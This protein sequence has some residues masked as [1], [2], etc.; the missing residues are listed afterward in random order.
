[1][2][3]A[4]VSGCLGLLNTDNSSFWAIILY[5]TIPG[6][7]AVGRLFLQWEAQ[8]LEACHRAAADAANAAPD[9]VDAAPDDA[10][11]DLLNAVDAVENHSLVGI[12]SRQQNGNESDES[13]RD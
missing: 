1:M 3:A 2:L 13:K 7:E 6:F 4:W 9:V 8:R 10:T 5:A 12:I 11:A